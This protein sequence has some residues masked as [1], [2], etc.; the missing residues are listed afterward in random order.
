MIIGDGNIMVFSFDYL[1]LEFL[2]IFLSIIW[3]FRMWLMQN[4]WTAVHVANS[5]APCFFVENPSGLAQNLGTVV[6][7]SDT[8]ID[9]DA[10]LK[11]MVL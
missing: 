11:N 3:M 2:L 6:K 5:L 7:E 10:Q 4:T 1:I 9:V 8:D